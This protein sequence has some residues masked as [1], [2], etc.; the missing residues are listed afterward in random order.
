MPKFLQRYRT[1]KIDYLVI[2]L[3]IRWLLNLLKVVRLPPKLVR[4]EF[5]KRWSRKSTSFPHAVTKT[6]L[7]AAAKQKILKYYSF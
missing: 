6:C 1:L 2:R 4:L 7:K 5:G 3:V